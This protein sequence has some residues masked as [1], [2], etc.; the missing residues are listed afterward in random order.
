MVRE[1]QLVVQVRKKKFF[2]VI[3]HTLPMKIAS[4]TIQYFLKPFMSLVMQGC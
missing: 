3:F 1:A 4:D 2:E